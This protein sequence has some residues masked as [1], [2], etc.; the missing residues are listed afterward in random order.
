MIFLQVVVTSETRVRRYTKWL[1]QQR[2]TK[3]EWN[4][5][6]LS[7]QLFTSNYRHCVNFFFCSTLN[8]LTDLFFLRT[9]HFL[10]SF[11]HFCL[12]NRLFTSNLEPVFFSGNTELSAVHHPIF[13]SLWNETMVWYYSFIKSSRCTKPQFWE[14][15]LMLWMTLYLF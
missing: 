1:G 11:V 4:A 2:F 3:S 10:Q 9:W 8:P 13:N 7:I 14:P 5:L 15:K 6:R 12:N